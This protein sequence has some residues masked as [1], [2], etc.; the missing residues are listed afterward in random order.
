MGSDRAHPFVSK[1]GVRGAR[2]PS[3]AVDRTGDCG[4]RGLRY[5]GGNPS[6]LASGGRHASCAAE[7]KEYSTASID[8]VL[9]ERFRARLRRAVRSASTR[10]RTDGS[11]ATSVPDT[12]PSVDDDASWFQSHYNEAAQQ[13]IDFLAGVNISMTGQD[14]ADIGC[15]DGIIDLGLAHKAQ[16]Q[17][18]VGYDL[19]LVDD[20]IRSDLT[21]AAAQAGVPPELPPCLGFAR[22]EP[23]SIPADDETFD[24][25]VTWSASE[26]IAEPAGVFREMRRIIRPTGVLFLQLWPFYYSAHG[27]HLW[28][29]FPG[30]NFV[31]LYRSADEIAAVLR[32]NPRGPTPGWNERMLDEFRTLNRITL[33]D[34]QRALLAGGFAVRLVEVDTPIVNLPAEAAR[35]RLAD[36]AI[37]GVKLLAL[38]R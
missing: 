9:T 38:P 18:L 33:D 4:T 13:I 30:E 20:D 3:R 29:W 7:E 15:G 1:N 28:D 31:H 32:A 25:V 37:A 36:L 24:F 8:F 34:L 16:P 21:S 26:H 22:S 27:S 12:A 5:R 10:G 11:A 17:R 23:L 6:D 14:V 19:D 2:A 35:Y